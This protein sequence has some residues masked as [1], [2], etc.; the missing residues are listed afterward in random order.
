M[1]QA[2]IES[3]VEQ[4]IPD[5]RDGGANHTQDAGSSHIETERYGREGNGKQ[6]ADYFE[7]DGLANS[8]F[9]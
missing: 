2:V 5:G 4:V 7:R 6:E 9:G 3:Q 8:I 1:L